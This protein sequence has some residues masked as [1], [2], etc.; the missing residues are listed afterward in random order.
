MFVSFLYNSGIFKIDWWPHT[1]THTHKKTN[2]GQYYTGFRFQMNFI[3]F[4]VSGYMKNL[5]TQFFDDSDLSETKN[6]RY[7]NKTTNK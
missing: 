4:F 7:M 1:H 3:L 6:S 5:F 2:S